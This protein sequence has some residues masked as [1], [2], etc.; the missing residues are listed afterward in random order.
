MGQDKVRGAFELLGKHRNFAVFAGN[1]ALPI[2]R[3]AQE[4]GPMTE[5]T[6]LDRLKR[7][8]LSFRHHGCDSTSEPPLLHQLDNS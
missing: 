1:D 5:D 7:T 8:H 2:W 3:N 4:I 6:L